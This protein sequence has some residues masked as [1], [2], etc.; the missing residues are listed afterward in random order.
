MGLRHWLAS[1]ETAASSPSCP[2]TRLSARLK[3][4][5]TPRAISTSTTR[6]RGNYRVNVP[7]LATSQTVKWRRVDLVAVSRQASYLAPVRHRDPE[8]SSEWR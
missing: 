3:K 2:V 7:R 5:W 8:T 1:K 6:V 4:P